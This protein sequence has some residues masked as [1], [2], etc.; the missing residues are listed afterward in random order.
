VRPLQIPRWIQLVSLPLTLLLAWTLAAE[1]TTTLEVF[2]ISALIALLLNPLVHALTALK[3]PRGMSVLIVYLSF[4]GA[5]AGVAV[6]AGAAAVSQVSNAAQTV[7]DQ[8]TKPANGGPTPADQK[9]D[10]LQ[11]WLDGH[12]LERV[13]IRTA[14]QQ[15]VAKIEKQGV[16]GYAQKAIDVG[17]TLATAIVSGVIHLI[18]ILVV[19]IYMLLDAPRLARF[20]NRLV[21]PGPDGRELGREA[22]RALA[23][24]VRGQFMVSLIIGLSVGLTMEAFGLL[25]IWPAAS[26]YALFFGL[27]AMV[28]EAIPYVGPIIGAVPPVVLA[29]FDRPITAL[30][31]AL[32]FLAIHQLEGHVVV[33]RVMGNA[34]RSH[35]LAVIFGLLAGAELFGVIG[36]ILAL[37]ILAVGRAVV[38]F[39]SARVSFE[40]WP[41]VGLADGGLDVAVPVVAEG[42]RGGPDGAAQGPRPPAPAPSD[43]DSM[44]P[45]PPPRGGPDDDD[46]A[47]ASVTSRRE[48]ER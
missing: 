7:Q 41:R 16:T 15:A 35:P 5:V 42:A 9:I 3:L 8:F 19:S 45:R 12:G 11:R 26:R 36:A 31:V 22:Q 46:A 29:L 20:V 18:L 14:G 47:G 10:D 48:G 25:G 27:F 30:W 38:D 2:V 34:L 24:Y 32:A 17:S 39:L 6:V 13:H 44:V 23:S 33:P 21:P 1:L 37:P 43:P 4:F 40:P 28:T